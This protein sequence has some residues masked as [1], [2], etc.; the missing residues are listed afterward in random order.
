MGKNVSLA[1]R[2]TAQ[3]STVI[4]GEAGLPSI[5][6]AAAGRE[7]DVTADVNEKYGSETS[8]GVHTNQRN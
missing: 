4:Y 3:N 2:S 5:L 7:H 8:S 6:L 1:R